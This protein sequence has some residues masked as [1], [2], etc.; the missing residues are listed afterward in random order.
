MSRFQI[1]PTTYAEV[2]AKAKHLLAEHW[3]EVALNKGLMILDPDEQR[4]LA[5]EAT[6]AFFALAAW[7]GDNLVGYSG[8]FIGQHLH[9][10]G[11]RYANNDVLFVSKEHRASPLGLRLIRETVTE[12]TRRGARLMLW[13]GKYNT[14]LA[15]LLPKMDY[16]V[17]DVIYSKELPASN[18]Q[19][20][21]RFDEFDAAHEALALAHSTPL[22][23]EFTARQETPG[24]AHHA[25]RCIVLRGPDTE[26]LD[27]EAVFNCLESVDL[28]TIERTPATVDLCAAA[29]RALRVKQ[30]GRVMLVEL[31]PG[32]S[33]DRHRDEGAYADHFE[34]FHLALISSPGNL[35][36]CGGETI[37]MAPGELWKFNHR[38]EHE[39]VNHSDTPRVHLIIDAV[40]E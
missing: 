29:C 7:D 24:S 10:A 12:A 5:L 23:D 34:R 3:D 39:V 21:G 4:Y 11:L 35:F 19:L 22:W 9:Y 1:L 16:K 37:H 18:F 14:P 27:H 17:Q 26:N 38:I 2:N 28:P 32:A 20:Q 6:G 15:D 36:T 31:P 30:L 25:T 13:H 8:N 40:I 33:I